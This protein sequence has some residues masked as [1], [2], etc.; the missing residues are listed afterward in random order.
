V[1]TLR[2]QASSVPTTR[3][4]GGAAHP[5]ALE[6]FLDT[7]TVLLLPGLMIYLGFNAGGYFAG[8]TGWAATA[9]AVVLAVRVAVSGRALTAPSL[10][11]ALAAAVLALFA[12]WTLLSGGWSGNYGRSLIEFDR[13]LLYLL[14]LLVFGSIQAPRSAFRF[15]PAGFALGAV[16]LCAAG[17]A[18]R[19]LPDLWP[20]ALPSEGNRLAYPVTYSNGLGALASLGIITCLHLASWDREPAVARI[21]AAAALPLLT[22][23]LV[24]TFSRGAILAGAIGVLVY[25]VLGRPRGLFTALLG[26]LPFVVLAA[27]AAYDAELLASEHPTSS[28]AMEQGTDVARTCGAAMLGAAAFLAALIPAERWLGRR[29][30]LKP[31]RPVAAGIGAVLV[32]GVAFA[33]AIKGPDAVHSLREEIVGQESSG[34]KLTRER[35]TNPNDLANLGGQTRVKYWRVAIDAFEDE[36]IR[37]TGVGTFAKRWARDRPTPESATEGHSVYLETLGELGLV[38]ASLIVVVLAMLVR[39]FITRLG[40]GRRPLQAAALAAALAWLVHAGIDWDWEL[41]VLTVWLFAFGGC[42]LAASPARL[43]RLPAPSPLMRLIVVSACLLMAVTPAT[44]AV[45]QSRL[46]ESVAA[47]LEGDC[48][49][50][51]RLASAANSALAPRAEPYEILAYCHSRA[52]RHRQAVASMKQAIERDPG[53]WEL[54]YGLALVRAVG[55]KDPTSAARR[56]LRLNPREPLVRSA[57]D[58]FAHGNPRTWRRHARTA[59]LPLP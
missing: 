26:T 43:G 56:A 52:G 24:L 45:S 10:S 46:D 22:A 55:G 5:L 3:A 12:G 8:T 21:S 50:A 47:L 11:L 35:V 40:R 59:R 30:V 7:A 41:P 57:V 20:F 28:A 53:H 32:I 54:L 38:G 17:L 44:I 48:E 37:G 39:P 31:S 14:V 13:T 2:T 15:L 34:G 58:S 49:T 4:A 36:P 25:A 33:A 27:Y 1:S 51:E 29:R 23:T 16:I 9:L 18:T 6:R 19:T 42:A